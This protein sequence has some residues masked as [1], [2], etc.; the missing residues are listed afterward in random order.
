MKIHMLGPRRKPAL[1]TTTLN[2]SIQ[3]TDKLHCGHELREIQPHAN[4]CKD[5]LVLPRAVS[6]SIKMQLQQR[7]QIRNLECIGGSCAMAAAW[8]LSAD[9]GSLAHHVQI[10]TCAGLAT[11][12]AATFPKK[13]TNSVGFRTDLRAP[14]SNC[15]ANGCRR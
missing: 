10:T 13:D 2:K 11:A 14:R 1:R 12:I 4:A 15:P 3:A 7:L 6:R 5:Q 8:H 9:C